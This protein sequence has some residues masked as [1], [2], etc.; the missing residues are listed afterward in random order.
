MDPVAF[1]GAFTDFSQT[2]G[3]MQINRKPVERA[4]RGDEIG[5]AVKEPVRAG[6]LVFKLQP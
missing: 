5:L 6:D 1:K 4:V 2:V 3:S